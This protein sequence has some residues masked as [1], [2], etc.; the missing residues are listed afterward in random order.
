MGHEFFISDVLYRLLSRQ[1]E[2]DDTIKLASNT[3]EINGRDSKLSALIQPLLLDSNKKTRKDFLSMIG[4]LDQYLELLEINLNKVKSLIA[5]MEEAGGYTVRAKNYLSEEGGYEK[6]S[7]RLRDCENFYNLAISRN[8]KLIDELS[9]II[10]DG[11]SHT[12]PSPG[13]NLL[14]GEQLFVR[15]SSDIDPVH[16]HLTIQ[17]VDLRSAALSVRPANFETLMNVQY[18]RIDIANMIDLAITLKNII[19]ADLVALSTRKEFCESAL[20][21]LTAVVERVK[22]TKP[23]REKNAASQ[24]L[25][26]KLRDDQ[27]PLAIEPQLSLLKAFE[28]P[29]PNVNNEIVTSSL[30]YE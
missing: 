3:E 4:I 21:S 5:G 30:Q 17:G 13:A 24:L 29:C 28:N 7:E 23:I 12:E 22:S 11:S 16:N 26:L 1:I 10:N 6:F 25:N 19:S 27:Y 2:L 8:D 18:S 9:I 20:A 14:K 15:L